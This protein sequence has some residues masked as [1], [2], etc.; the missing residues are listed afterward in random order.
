[1]GFEIYGFKIEPR[2][3]TGEWGK[4]YERDVTRNL[5]LI[6][7]VATGQL[8]FNAVR[9]HKIPILISPYN[10]EEGSCNATVENDHIDPAGIIH[11]R[12]LITP[13]LHGRGSWCWKFFAEELGGTNGGLAHEMLFHELIHA[14]RK[15]TKSAKRTYSIPPTGGAMASYTNE[16]EF[17]A[18]LTTNIFISD[19][20]NRNKSGLRASHASKGPLA[21]ELSSSF[22]FFRSSKHT[23]ALVDRF[24]KQN[25]GFT[26]ALAKIPAPFNPLAAYYTNQQKAR[27]LS[28]LPST[29]ERDVQSIERRIIQRINPPRNP[30]APHVP[31]LDTI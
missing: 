6:A 9:F 7:Q 29:L 14:F 27:Q 16:E 12:V 30:T 19:P 31:G 22:E 4:D 25:P 23:F 15:I 17:I 11:P 28:E 20:S 2:E 18:V 1:L 24:C 21:K 8:F 3:L 10:N 26:A 5:A 13:S